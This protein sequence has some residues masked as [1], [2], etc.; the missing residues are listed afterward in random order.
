MAATL[1]IYHLEGLQSIKG[2]RYNIIHKPFRLQ[3]HHQI[4]RCLELAQISMNIQIITQVCHRELNSTKV[5]IL[6]RVRASNHEDEFRI[7]SALR[8]ELA[9]VKFCIMVRGPA[10]TKCPRTMSSQWAKRKRTL[11]KKKTKSY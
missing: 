3:R 1:I 10:K 5:T 11:K 6:N 2:I 9:R 4:V 8:Q 7:S